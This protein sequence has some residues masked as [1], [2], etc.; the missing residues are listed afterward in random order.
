MNYWFKKHISDI[1]VE[2]K[3]NNINKIS[4]TFLN[5]KNVENNIK[6]FGGI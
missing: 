6:E 4:E 2:F 5:G 1:N 3:Y